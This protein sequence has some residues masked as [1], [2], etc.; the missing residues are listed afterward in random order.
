MSSNVV[1]ALLKRLIPIAIGRR[2]NR[3]ML[4]LCALPRDVAILWAAS[5]AKAEVGVYY[6]Y[7]Y[8]P[9]PHEN[10]HGGLTKFQCMQDVFPNS[11]TR[12]NILYMVS[13]EI[14]PGGELQ[15]AWL[16]RIKRKRVVW[17]Q[18]GVAYPEWADPGWKQINSRMATLLREADYVFYQS[19]FC[20]LSA[21]EFLG[22]RNGPS[23]I[24]YNAVDTCT[25]TPADSD[26]SPR[27]LVLLLGGTQD[28]YYRLA[29]ALEVVSHIVEHRPDVQLL[30]TG[31]LCWPHENGIHDQAR[32]EGQAHELVKRVGLEN[33]VNFLG[34]YTQVEAP[35]I[36]RRAHL[37]LHTKVNDPCPRLVVEAMA[38]GLPVVYSRS[39][40]VP[41]LVG[42]D[43]GIGVQAEVS[44]E[45]HIPPDSKAMAQAV[46][47]IAEKR[48]QF[49]EAARQRAVEKF[50]LKPWIQRHR[51]VF[52]S[53][54]R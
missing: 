39:G 43:A 46:L 11:P 44:W 4:A 36:F 24:L 27:D 22:E 35:S 16:A 10:V 3:L 6:G 45:R 21:D 5:P 1:R 50:D 38:C 47:M 54:L 49:A 14:P 37:L 25:L 17:N 32:C 52:E 34:P 53:L 19:H 23:E 13:S 2:L 9:G 28:Q 29:C 33:R 42:D 12:F 15:K 20:K 30:V 18:N 51:E 7:H 40:G 8:I 26:P 31:R 41:E 48:K